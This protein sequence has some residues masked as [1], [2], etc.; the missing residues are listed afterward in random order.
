MKVPRKF[1]NSSHSLSSFSS[2]LHE[3]SRLLEN[4]EKTLSRNC[5][6]FNKISSASDKIFSGEFFSLASER[7]RRAKT[8]KG[9]RKEVA[10]ARCPSCL[11]AMEGNG[12]SRGDSKTK[13]KVCWEKHEVAF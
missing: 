10:E 5:S 2:L 1:F 7:R 4:S 11:I 13:E 3:E 9:R 12:G 6:S 8:N